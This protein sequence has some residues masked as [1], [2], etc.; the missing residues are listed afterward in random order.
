MKTP[1]FFPILA[2]LSICVMTAYAQDGQISLPDVEKT[3]IKQSIAVGL[4][5]LEKDTPEFGDF[6]KDLVVII[7]GAIATPGDDAVEFQKKVTG[8][9]TT[10]LHGM[11]DLRLGARW[12]ASYN[13]ALESLTTGEDFKRENVSHW[14]DAYKLAIDALNQAAAERLIPTSSDADRRGESVRKVTDV[15]EELK[16]NLLDD[17]YPKTCREM[18][19]A[20]EKVLEETETTRTIPDQYKTATST[21][22]IDLLDA[23]KEMADEVKQLWKDA[24]NQ[25]FSELQKSESSKT[26]EGWRFALG[27]LIDGLKKAVGDDEEF[28][29][30]R[31]LGATSGRSSSSGRSVG[32]YSY[33]VS[34]GS[35]A[36]VHH[37]RKM[38][39]IFRAHERRSYRIRRIRARK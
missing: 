28:I 3:R 11:D 20:L 27:V 24:L 32:S 38:S 6:C 39:R 35:R 1:R 18:I 31:T 33:R 26:S 7:Q 37:E 14:V 13:T 9:V 23:E 4:V 17:E 30:K 36:A 10:F 21:A 2:T 22:I 29:A 16:L 8:A 19:A 25:F 5:K 15:L 12:A 34:G